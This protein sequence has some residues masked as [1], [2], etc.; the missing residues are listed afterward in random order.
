MVSAA[1]HTGKPNVQ[2]I[3]SIGQGK[4]LVMQRLCGSTNQVFESKRAVA[5][6]TQHPKIVEFE[7]ITCTDTPGLNDM[8]IPTKVWGERYNNSEVFTNSEKVDLN[9]VLF[10][11]SIRPSFADFIVLVVLLHA[12]ENVDA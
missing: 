10:K 3:G 12:L 5:S 2:V 1:R 8:S 6:V 4:S 7:N 9:L 11:C